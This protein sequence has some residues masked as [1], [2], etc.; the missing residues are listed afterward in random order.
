MF[1]IQPMHLTSLEYRYPK[2]N[3]LSLVEAMASDYHYQD[4]L[5][6][7]YKEDQLTVWT[8][9]N[10]GYY[11]EF[12]KNYNGVID[13]YFQ[14]TWMNLGITWVFTED[15]LVG[16]VDDGKYYIKEVI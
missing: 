4:K 7:F 2:Y 12:L 1:D 14:R 15:K 3:F 6:W 16:K 8:Q 11:Q 5:S 13:A 10:E 9:V